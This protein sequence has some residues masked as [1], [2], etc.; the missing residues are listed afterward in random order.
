MLVMAQISLSPTS[1][2]QLV[3]LVRE[4]T[5]LRCL[6]LGNVGDFE[7]QLFDANSVVLFADALRANAVLEEIHF[8]G[9][10]VWDT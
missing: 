6:T 5:S 7:M 8:N 2:P 9:I 3:R 10:G 1:V 4:S